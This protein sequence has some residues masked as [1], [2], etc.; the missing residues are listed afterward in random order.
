MDL[1]E[2]S[3]RAH[4]DH[5]IAAPL[6]SGSVDGLLGALTPTP[7]GRVL[8]LGCG[9]GEWLLRLLVARP[10]LH[11]VGVDL[12][13]PALEE[14]R[15]RTGELGLEERVT[16][17]EGDGATWSDGAVDVVLCIGATHALGGPAGTLGAMRGHLA[18]GG[19]ALLGDELW[20]RPPSP[21][22]QAALDAGPDDLPDLPGLVATAAAHGFEVGYGHVSTLEEWDDYE[23]SWTGS[24]V[25]WALHEAA[26]E[27]DR[28]QALDAARTHR[29]GWLRGYRGELGFATLVLHLVDASDVTGG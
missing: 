28:V 29:D 7:G 25:R 16:W 1:D 9:T 18:P 10:D 14:A 19:Q 11:G 5:P 8:D 12:S 3:R 17:V 6:G 15:R 4:A 26:G 21:E 27:D 2:L 22:A 24:L 13:A 20:E 23:W